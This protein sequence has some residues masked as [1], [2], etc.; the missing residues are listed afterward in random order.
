MSRETR[1]STRPTS[2]FATALYVVSVHGA[3][4]AEYQVKRA[5]LLDEIVYFAA[6][7]P[8]G[9]HDWKKPRRADV[10]RGHID[11]IGR[12]RWIGSWED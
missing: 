10:K 11:I 1:R 5:M 8:A 6:D 12:V 7:N 2:A 9:D 4:H 3:A